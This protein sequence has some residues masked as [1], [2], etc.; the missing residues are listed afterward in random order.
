MVGLPTACDCHPAC[1]WG[2]Q[3]MVGA[4]YCTQGDW[5]CRGAEGKGGPAGEPRRRAVRH[6][7]PRNFGR[8]LP[9]GQNRFLF[10]PVNLLSILT[11]LIYAR[12]TRYG[13]R[14]RTTGRLLPAASRAGGRAFDGRWGA[15]P[16][17]MSFVTTLPPAASKTSNHLFAIIGLRPREGHASGSIA[18]R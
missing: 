3:A 16:F 7:R 13:R 9:V 4:K 11:V 12:L 1:G 15:K 10:P 8:V 14:R 6:F 5:R 2:R 17:A 18:R